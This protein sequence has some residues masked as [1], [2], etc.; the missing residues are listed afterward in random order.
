MSPRRLRLLGPLILLGFALVSLVAGLAFGGGAAPQLLLDAGPFVRWGLPVARLFVNLGAAGIIGTLVL[1]LF[2]LKVGE[3]EFETAMNVASVSA[4][5]FTIASAVT[6]FFTYL[7]AFPTTVRPDAEFGAQLAAFMLDIPMG[8]AWLMTVV[9]GAIITVVAFAVRGWLGTALLLAL[10]IAA[11][12]PMATQGHTAGAAGHNIAVTGLFLHLV[13]AAVWLGG[14]ILLIVIRPVIDRDKM[15]RVLL[16][17]SSLALAAFLVV[18]FSGYASAAL[19]VGAWDA[20]LTPYGILI[21]VKVTALLAIGVLGAIY[22]RAIINRMVGPS[23]A[24][25]APRR[26][27]DASAAASTNQKRSATRTS[28]AEPSRAASRAGQVAADR[29][30]WGL[31]VLELVLMGIASGAAVALARTA[32]PVPQEAAEIPTPAQRLTDRLLPPELG[33]LQWLT[34]WH[35]DLLWIV[36]CA[37]GL[38]FYLAGVRRMRRRGDAWP[39]YRTIAWVAGV[40]LLFWVTNGPINAYQEYLFSVHMLGHMALA[41]GIPILLVTGAPVTLALRTIRKRDDG[42]RGGREWIMWAVNTPFAKVITNPFVTAAI[43]VVSLWVFYYTGIFRWSMEDHLGHQWMVVHFLISGYLFAQSLIG[44][45]PVPYRLPH[46]GRLVL[47]LL[48][49]AVHAFFGVAIMAQEGLFVA[50]WFGAMGRTWGGT[51][52]DDQRAGGGVAWSVGEIPSLILAITVAIQ[53]SRSDQKEQTRL[54]R[55]ADRTG[56]AELADYN[57]QLAGIAARDAAREAAQ[58]GAGRQ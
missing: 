8:R 16:R 58:E 41:M 21:L 33:P 10:S 29:R 53:W 17:Y 30:F 48:V 55:T 28:P 46:A 11:L 9:A 47:L 25:S 40:L 13:G 51:P 39:L 12:Y 19:R 49:M 54:D 6:A 34:E 24:V 7:N 3:R 31:I 57:A 2:A 27:V 38:F 23:R 14:L 32:P 4:A 1:A 44:I 37:F 52:M 56:D 50:E 26:R 20:I 18:A 15:T 45:D 22:R 36:A 35:V 42:T 5:I 43:F